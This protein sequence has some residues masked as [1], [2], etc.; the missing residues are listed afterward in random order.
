MA[1]PEC[2][3]YHVN[4]NGSYILRDTITGMARTYYF[5]TLKQAIK[6]HRKV[7]NLKGKHLKVMEV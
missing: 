6:K 3:F 5:S 7:C 2:L 4:A 1:Q